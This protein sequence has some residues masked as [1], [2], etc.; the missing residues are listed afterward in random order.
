MEIFSKKVLGA[1]SSLQI[2]MMKEGGFNVFDQ[3]QQS[4]KTLMRI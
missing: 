4:N 1:D 3:H 2:V